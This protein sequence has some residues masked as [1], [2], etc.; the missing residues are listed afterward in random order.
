MARVFLP[1]QLH[2]LTGGAAELELG[3]EDYRSLM[4]ELDRRYPGFRQA[5]EQDF[6]LVIDGDIIND[7]LL[8]TL[9]PDSEIHF[10]HRLGGG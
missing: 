8:E 9:P 7:P 3:A 1:Q 5:I 6:A 10:L 4:A 2:R